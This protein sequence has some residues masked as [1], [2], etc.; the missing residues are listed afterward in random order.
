MPPFQKGGEEGGN[1]ESQALGVLMN[2]IAKALSLIL[3]LFVLSGYLLFKLR[4]GNTLSPS[5]HPQRQTDENRSTQMAEGLIRSV[6]TERGTFVLDTGRQAITFAFDP[7]TKMSGS[8]HS[9]TF[10]TP[11]SNLKAR[12]RYSQKAGQY[13]AR[14]VVLLEAAAP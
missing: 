11:T 12:V 2:K 9:V 5:R 8:D 14:D 7:S 13:I 4:L 1:K 3:V 6:D 10:A